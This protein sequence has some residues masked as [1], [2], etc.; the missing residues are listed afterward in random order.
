MDHG[1]ALFAAEAIEARLNGQ[2]ETCEQLAAHSLVRLMG[3]AQVLR[4]NAAAWAPALA[5]AIALEAIARQGRQAVD[6]PASDDEKIIVDKLRALAA[7]P[8]QSVPR[9][10]RDR[11]KAAKILLP[12]RERLAG[13]RVSL[14]LH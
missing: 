8:P 11:R 12:R 1:D 5:G 6:L 13:S 4:R 14:A 9:N 3:F 10:R 2:A 7:E